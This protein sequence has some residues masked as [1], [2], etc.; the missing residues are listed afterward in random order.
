MEE[1]VDAQIKECQKSLSLAS[2]VL[3]SSEIPQSYAI[4]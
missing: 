3:Q 1:E 2:S 4:L